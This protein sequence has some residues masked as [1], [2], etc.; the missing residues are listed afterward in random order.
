M[1]TTFIACHL[2]EELRK[3]AMLANI[4]IA[5]AFDD[6][7][8]ADQLR[9]DA[10]SCFQNCPD[11]VG[12]YSYL[13]YALPDH[14]AVFVSACYES[15]AIVP[16]RDDPERVKILIPFPTERPS[17]VPSPTDDRSLSEVFAAEFA[18]GTCCS[19]TSCGDNTPTR[20]AEIEKQFNKVQGCV[21][22]QHIPVHS[23]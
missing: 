21:S 9:T 11:V 6:P 16:D 10:R 18:R 2:A 14:I 4:I 23:T 3:F 22:D 7:G 20:S 17:W 12:G 5:K 19:T 8:F 15:F 1:E 13:H